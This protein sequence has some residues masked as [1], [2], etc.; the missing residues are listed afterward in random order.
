[1]RYRLD[2][3]RRRVVVLDVD[4]RRDPYRLQ[5]GLNSRLYCVSG[6]AESRAFAADS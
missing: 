4:H 1:V 2:E 3:D 6:P 5:N